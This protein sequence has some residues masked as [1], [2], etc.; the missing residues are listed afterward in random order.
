M[1]RY[2]TGCFQNN[3]TNTQ[4]K[5]RENIFESNLYGLLDVVKVINLHHKKYNG[6]QNPSNLGSF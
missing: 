3:Y 2:Y 6:I 4:I 5:S 1:H